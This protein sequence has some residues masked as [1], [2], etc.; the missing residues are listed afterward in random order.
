MDVDVAV[1]LIMG[2]S[3]FVGTIVVAKDVL[4]KR[5]QKYLKQREAKSFLQK[6]KAKMSLAKQNMS[7]ETKKKISKLMKGKK[8]S[9][10]T[11]LKISL[12]NIKYDPDYP[13]CDIWKDEEYKNDI[14]KDYC[15]NA[16]CKKISK[17]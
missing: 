17:N 12:T 2:S 9:A 13:Y 1:L 15:E 3:I 14:R 5:K 7:D 11:K 10:E 4:Q 8:R 16:D 6:Q